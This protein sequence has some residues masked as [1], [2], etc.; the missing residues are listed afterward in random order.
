MTVSREAQLA[1]LFTPTC[2]P[3]FVGAAVLLDKPLNAVSQDDRD[4]V[5]RVFM[6][7]AAR[8][9]SLESDP[10]GILR[11]ALRGAMSRAAAFEHASTSAEALL[12]P[13]VAALRRAADLFHEVGSSAAAEDLVADCRNAILADTLRTK[14]RTRAQIKSLT[15]DGFE[16]CVRALAD[17]GATDVTIHECGDRDMEH[18]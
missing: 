9:G 16:L 15:A 12:A 3:Y 17:L 5:K 4:L 2:D 6:R 1:E 7:I 10:V 14:L 11:D 18:W 8:R 13:L